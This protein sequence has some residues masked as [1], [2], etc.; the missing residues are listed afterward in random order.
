MKI[1]LGYGIDDDIAVFRAIARALDGL[2]VEL[3]VDT[4]HAYGRAEALRLGHVLDEYALRWYEE[5][6]VPEDIE[7]Y[8]QLRAKLRTPYDRPVARTNT[9]CMAFAT[10]SARMR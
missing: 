10:C 8:R 3:M 6:V 4:N 9:P 5:P 1:K 7:G 2:G